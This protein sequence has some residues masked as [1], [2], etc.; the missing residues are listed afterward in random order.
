MGDWKE[1]TGSEK[2]NGTLKGD[3]LDIHSIFITNFYDI[4]SFGETQT[5]IQQAIPPFRGTLM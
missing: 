1:I 4:C 2:R 5:H 3:T